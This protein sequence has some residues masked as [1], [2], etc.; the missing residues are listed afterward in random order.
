MQIIGLDIGFGF[1][2][3][4]DGSRRT[5][6]KSLVGEAPDIAFRE[7]LVAADGDAPSLH[8]ALEDEPYFVGDLAER[9]SSVRQ[10]TLDQDQLIAEFS[11]RLGVAA[12]AQLARDN[13]PLHVVTGLPVRYYRRHR[14]SLAR[15]LTGSHRVS[16]YGPDGK[17]TAL[18]VKVEKVRVVPQPFGSLFGAM[19]NDIGKVSDTALAREKVGVIDIGFR[20]ADY[21]VA[22]RTRY[23]ERA[24]GTSE[25]GI[26]QAFELVAAALQEKSGVAVELYRL[27]QGVQDGA[28]K[29]RGRNYD[30]SGIR[31][32]T[33]ERLARAV[34]GEVNRLWDQ[35]WDIDTILLTGGG[36]S[37]LAP[38]L[39]PL[40][41]GEVRAVE[42]EDARFN[43][44]DGYWRYGVH[45]WER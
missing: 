4:T 11:R 2:K 41:A 19:L 28:I 20:T 7:P 13:E 44:V 17:E 30:L 14:D 29:V 24:S 43:N 22:E 3:V 42:N 35:D 32:R 37:V 31:E 18:T 45:L 8:L 21:A 1:T 38:H 6:F 40:V 23:S 5:L 16:L 25:H 27:Y 10:Y 15:Q 39:A 12:L 26:A 34:A 36:G 9:Q 33:F